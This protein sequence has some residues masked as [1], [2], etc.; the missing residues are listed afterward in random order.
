M[1]PFEKNR[2][3]PVEVMITIAINIAVVALG[4]YV[5]VFWGWLAVGPKS[6]FG[7]AA[8]VHSFRRQPPYK[9]GHD[10]QPMVNLQQCDEK[11]LKI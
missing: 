10:T 6:H 7:K 4:Y 1:D 2:L 8:D 11:R 3:L 9:R 5:M